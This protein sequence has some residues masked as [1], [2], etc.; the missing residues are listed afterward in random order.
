MGAVRGD[1]ASARA[2]AAQ[3]AEELDAI[4][5]RVI[6]VV[7]HA[8]RTPVTTIAGMTN[9]LEAAGDDTTKAM[10]I[11][12]LARNAQRL[13]VLLDDLLQAAGVTTA[14]PVDD[15]ESRSVHDAFDTAWRRL[16][17]P[18]SLTFS[19]AD[20]Q[21]VARAAALDRIAMIVL[22][23][24]LKYGHGPVAVTCGRTVDGVCIEVESAGDGPTDEELDRAFEL[25]Y[26]G[27]HAV[28]SAPG[29]GIGLAVARELARAEGGTVVLERRGS[30]IVA[31][32]DL[33]S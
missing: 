6:N 14:L 11:D 30:S 24:A 3:S 25:L 7:G 10:L 4:R 1:D 28:T 8:L 26:R 27:E 29:L 31:R 13:E 16:E 17:G 18:D 33:P 19:G 32:V 2:A 23:N 5:R 21:V 22:D 15:P 20:V 12:G 9:A